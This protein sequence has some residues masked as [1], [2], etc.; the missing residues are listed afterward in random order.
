M[1]K[2]IPGQMGALVAK[3]RKPT[4]PTPTSPNIAQ[5]YVQSY[6]EDSIINLA[7]KDYA[8]MLL[9]AGEH[10]QR[11][12]MVKAAVANAQQ[13]AE[14]EA[15]GAGATISERTA[16]ILRSKARRHRRRRRRH[17]N[18]GEGRKDAEEGRRP[19]VMGPEAELD[20]IVRIL[21]AAEQRED[22]N[23]QQGFAM[24]SDPGFVFHG[25]TKMKKPKRRKRGAALLA[26]RAAKQH[27]E[28]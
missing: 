27:E 4:C 8:K 12:I 21:E 10:E 9:K 5:T 1:S 3:T 15:D 11:H 22:C 23:I 19:S 20:S 28:D 13:R 14:L 16:R 2:D 18:R 6:S 7:A 25:G 24:C 17:T 26:A